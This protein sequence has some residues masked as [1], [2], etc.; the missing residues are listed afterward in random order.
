A[1]DGEIIGVDDPKNMSM[2][3]FNGPS[4]ELFLFGTQLRQI[5]S[6][7]AGNLDVQGGLEPQSK[8]LGQDKML[9]ENSS[10]QTTSLQDEV[11]AHAT[12]VLK[13]LCWYWHHHPFQVQQSAHKVQD[14]T[15]T[16]TVTP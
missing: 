9:N 15:A 3:T 8:T 11:T 6:W 12:Q 14:M 2:M 16:R 10:R 13:R 1:S 5:F 7:L 4:N